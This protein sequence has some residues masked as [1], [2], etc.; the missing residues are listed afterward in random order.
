MQIYLFIFIYFKEK[1]LVEA[2]CCCWEVN[3]KEKVK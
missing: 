2:V 3:V 1:L